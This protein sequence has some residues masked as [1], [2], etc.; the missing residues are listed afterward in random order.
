MGLIFVHSWI[1]YALI[2]ILITHL[3][4]Q[5]LRLSKAA[6]IVNV[7]DGV[8]EL[9][10]LVVDYASEAYLGPFI[11][12]V[13]TNGLLLLFLAAWVLHEIEI[14]LLYVALLLIAIGR[15]GCDVPL[16]EFL[17]DQ[18]RKQGRA[19]DEE[20]VESRR[21]IWWR[22]AYFIGII[23]SLVFFTEA[24]WVNLCKICTIALAIAFALFLGGIPFF[25]LKKPT[26]SSSLNKVVQVIKA[27]ILKRHLSL[28]TTV[29]S[30]NDPP[31]IHSPMKRFLNHSITLGSSS[32]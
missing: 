19:E 7:H 3:T 18:F 21:K 17:A 32:L 5:G 10:V 25:E 23:A 12:I 13:C 6:M 29:S 11:V 8:T 27:A 1:E 20:R 22:L 16:K 26:E 4:D 2:A 28:N 30:D 14:K 24:S 31:I 15:A 9:L